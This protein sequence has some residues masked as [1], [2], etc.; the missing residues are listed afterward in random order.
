MRRSAVLGLAI[1]GPVAIG[2]FWALITRAG[3][4]GGIG[5]TCILIGVVLVM[6]GIAKAGAMD[7]AIDHMHPGAN[8]DRLG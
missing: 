4:P 5:G 8:I 1:G 6:L 7:T 3:I 2:V